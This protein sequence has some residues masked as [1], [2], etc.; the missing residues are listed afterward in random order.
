MLS[1]SMTTSLCVTDEVTRETERLGDSARAF[2]LPVLDVVAE[3]AAKVLDVVAARDEDQ[4]GHAGFGERVDGPHAPSACLQTGSRCLFVTLVSGSR[5]D[6]VP[7]ARTTP[8]MWMRCYEEW[9]RSRRRFSTSRRSSRATTSSLVQ[10]T[11]HVDPY[12]PE[13]HERPGEEK[14]WNV[15]RFAW[16]AILIVIAVV[17]WAAVR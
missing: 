3:V 4:V 7:P 11:S 14:A 8:F 9:P 2:L 6:P 17:I 13:T 15:M 10:P 1:A 5:R 12:T 16:I